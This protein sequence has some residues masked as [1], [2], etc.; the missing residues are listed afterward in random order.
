M[1]SLKRSFKRPYQQF[2]LVIWAVLFC[3]W[4][5][6]GFQKASSIPGHDSNPKDGS[7]VWWPRANDQHALSENDRPIPADNEVAHPRLQQR[8]LPIHPSSPD[9]PNIPIVV[10]LPADDGSHITTKEVE[11]YI[12]SIWDL[13]DSRFWRTEC[14]GQ[15]SLPR[16]YEFLRD[17][18]KDHHTSQVK[19]FFALDL[20][21]VKGLLP[22]LMGTLVHVVKMLG[23]KQCAISIVEGRSKDGSYAILLALKEKMETLGT[24]FYLVQSSIDPHADGVDR[25]GALSELRNMALSPLIEHS[26]NSTGP[27]L[28]NHDTIITFI[29]DVAICT[30]DIY[31]LLFQHI[32]QS[33]HQTCGMDWVHGGNVFYDSWVSRSMSGDLFFEVPQD[34]SFSFA[35]NMFWD[36]PLSK[37]KFAAHQPFQVYSCW[38]GMVTLSSAPFIDGQIKIRN[39]TK[40]ECYAGE[41]VTLAKDLWRL[42]YGKI[43][44]VP[45]VNM[46]YTSPDSSRAKKMKG[47]VHTHV[48]IDQTEEEWKG[49]QK[50]DWKVKPPGQVKC[51]P[52]WGVVSWTE[53]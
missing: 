31:E 24:P 11:E 46:G 21:E 36:H 7:H 28:Y 9:F 38:G 16:R 17:L 37:A 5:F 10:H 14:D 25:I 35:N 44:T 30:E 43:L 49:T 8:P 3:I 20:Y 4:L 23:P 15:G 2:L 42:G 50:I 18:A 52:G 41:P 13:G 29:N 1:I 53:P 26:K 33:A 34:V 45:T 39:S 12:T 22:R 6:V 51:M 40:D 48:K 32:F 47:W 19:Y 27:P